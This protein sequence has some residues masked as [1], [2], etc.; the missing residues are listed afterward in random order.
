MIWKWNFRNM[1]EWYERALLRKRLPKVEIPEN[2]PR[3]HFRGDID[4]VLQIT[5]EEVDLERGKRYMN[6]VQEVLSHKTKVRW[7]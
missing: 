6:N 3:D 1:F 5:K 7:I 4:R 2:N